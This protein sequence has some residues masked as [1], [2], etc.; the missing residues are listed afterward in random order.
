MPEIYPSFEELSMY[1]YIM[2]ASEMN[3]ILLH[4]DKSIIYI[5]HHALNQ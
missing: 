1:Y 4:Q 3:E 5:Y 2:L